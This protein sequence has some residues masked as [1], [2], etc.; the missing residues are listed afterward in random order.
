MEIG[1]AVLPFRYAFPLT[2]NTFFQLEVALR[3]FQM[4]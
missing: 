2:R 1:R 4:V 3:G